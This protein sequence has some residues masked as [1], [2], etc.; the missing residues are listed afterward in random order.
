M[1][2]FQANVLSCLT[3]SLGFLSLIYFIFR[4]YSSVPNCAP[5]P[6]SYPLV[7]NI[8]GFL[9]NRHRFHDWVAEMLSCT[10]DLT[11]Q[12]NGF[13]GLSHGICTANPVNLDH[14]LRSNFSNYVKGSRF[15]NVLQDLLGDGIFKVDGELWS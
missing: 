1:V 14:L 2:D 6:Q 12:V 3:I 9:L 7:G 4:K 11:L 10:P 8:I 13:L 5:S 15:H